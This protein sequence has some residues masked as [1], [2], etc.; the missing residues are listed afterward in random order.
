MNILKSYTLKYLRLNRRRTV[1]TIIGVILS[2]GLLCGTAVLA[3]S[4]WNMGIRTAIANSGNYHALFSGVPSAKAGYLTEN[5]AV[6]T[7][8]TSRVLGF[9]AL[10]NSRNP[11]KPYVFVVGYDANML[12][13]QPLK[14]VSGRFPQ[15]SGE[16]VVSQ[17]MISEKSEQVKAGEKITLSIGRRVKQGETLST[18]DSFETGERLAGIKRET[19]TVTGVIQKPEYQDY[20]CPGYT[21]I[22]YLDPNQLA[23]SDQVDVSLLL[24]NPVK[25]FQ[26]VPKMAQ[27]AGIKVSSEY[28]SGAVTLN[29]NTSL[30]T[31]LGA[32]TNSS[33]TFSMAIIV[34]VIVL[35]IMIGSIGVIY[36]AFS[37]SVGERKKQFGMLASVGAT[38]RQIRRMVFFEALIIGAVGIP[39]GILGGIAG[40]AAVISIASGILKSV[41]SN[42]ETLR[43]TVS[44]AVIAVTL[45][46]ASLT[47]W[48]SALIPAKRASKVSPIDAIRQS[49]EYG[50]IKRRK[51]KSTGLAGKLFGFEGELAIKSLKRDRKKYRTTVFSLFISIVMFVSFSSLMLYSFQETGTKSLPKYDFSAYLN[52]SGKVDYTDFIRQAQKLSEVKECEVIRSIDGVVQ[53]DS[54]GLSTEIKKLP[55]LI[56][57]LDSKTDEKSKSSC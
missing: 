47:I 21:A 5:S 23:P 35:I 15:K 55:D 13:T 10:Q 54:A 20:S 39:F 44:P 38:S 8:M 42:Y 27:E 49:S 18:S 22:A 17:D 32:R 26:T 29:Y 2:C 28:N 7:G 12:K 6:Q 24:K 57:G 33:Y 43:L 30:L 25:A 1:V 34:A 31:W 16:I 11:Y 53:T 41:L 48:I 56:Y 4:F 50:N 19:F 46:T 51:L 37:I 52:N 14:L 40:I 45:L 36:N 3:A 9:S